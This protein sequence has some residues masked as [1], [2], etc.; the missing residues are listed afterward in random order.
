M[1][2]LWAQ[3]PRRLQ[4]EFVREVFQRMA[5]EGPEVAAITP[6]AAYAPLF[7]LDRRERFGQ[8]GPDFR[9]LAPRA[10]FGPTLLQKGRDSDALAT[11]ALILPDQS[12]F[13]YAAR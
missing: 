8:T 6:R 12:E 10:G 1:G 13:A 11:P 7:V 9:R 3:S 2:S 5:V 4:K